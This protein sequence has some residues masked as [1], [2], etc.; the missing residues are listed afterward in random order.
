[1]DVA[2]DENRIQGGAGDTMKGG[3]IWNHP[4]VPP[5]YAIQ[6]YPIQLILIMSNW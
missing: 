3:P 4:H 6:S 2:T 1:M 5:S